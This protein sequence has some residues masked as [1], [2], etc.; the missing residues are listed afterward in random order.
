MSKILIKEIEKELSNLSVEELLDLEKTIVEVMKKK[1]KERKVNDWRGDFLKISTWTHLEQDGEVK[2]DK[3][4][5][6]K[7]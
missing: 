3:W 6:E 7:Y 4:R 1:I 5:I 2:V